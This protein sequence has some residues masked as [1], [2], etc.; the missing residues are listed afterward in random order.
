[1]TSAR[2]RRGRRLG[3][4]R[5]PHPGRHGPGQTGEGASRPVPWTLLRRAPWRHAAD[6]V[7]LTLVVVTFVLVSA[8][9]ASA[10][11]VVES[12]QNESV[13]RVL[14]AA[15]DAPALRQ[16]PVVR[17]TGGFEAPTEGS[18]VREALDGVPGLAPPQVLG[19]SFGEELTTSGTLW[20]SVVAPA[21][22]GAE[23]V[24]RR[25]AAVDDPAPL[26]V[27]ADGDG[28]GPAGPAVEGG[29]LAGRGR[30]RRPL[31]VGAGDSVTVSVT[32]GRGH[33]QRGAAGRGG[34]HGGRGRAAPRGRRGVD[35]LAG[36]VGPAP[37]GHRLRLARSRRC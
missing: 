20:R 32:R 16:Q 11:L 21:A 15:E 7:W 34:L 37:A 17:I 27:R 30:G 5:S 18:Q 12:A 31:A 28:D 10:P 22:G 35:V 24:D 6:R 19:I 33:G 3:H 2:S 13:R 14:E 29:R 8:A 26:L 9:G 36:P 23:P 25:L 1:M 4:A